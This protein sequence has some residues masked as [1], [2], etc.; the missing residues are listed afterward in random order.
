MKAA[1]FE[2]IEVFYNRK[3]LHSTLG[4]RSPIRH[5]EHWEREQHQEK[6]AA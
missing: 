5:R 4:Y 6:Q 3:P 1:T 2:Y